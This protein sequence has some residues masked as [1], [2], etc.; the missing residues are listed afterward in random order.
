MVFA[1]KMVLS[2][3]ISDFVPTCRVLGAFLSY[4]IHV[5]VLIL[6]DC[7]SMECA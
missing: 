2:E 6:A 7:H 3:I 4:S 5:T 1:K